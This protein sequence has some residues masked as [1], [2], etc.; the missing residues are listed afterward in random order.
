MTRWQNAGLPLARI[1]EWTV[2]ELDR[3]RQDPDLVVLDVRSD[4]EFAKGFVPGAQHI[5]APHLAERL[6]DLD[7]SKTIATYCGSGYR[8]S[9]AASLLQ[10]YGFQK[11]VNVPGSWAAWQAAR[12]PVE[13]HDRA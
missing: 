8:A 2:H 11:V 1:A 9:I 6:G 12:L 10:K 3:H 4:E 13:G 5:Y 7:R